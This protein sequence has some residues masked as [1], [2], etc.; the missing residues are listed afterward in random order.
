MTTSDVAV[1]T[2]HAGL[3]SL[4]LCVVQSKYNELQSKC[5][6]IME[7]FY[8]GGGAPGGAAPEPDFGGKEAAGGAQA[9]PKVEEVRLTQ[10]ARRGEHP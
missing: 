9:G 10:C 3:S 8:K 4:R 2:D 7:A 5:S 1:R 6:S